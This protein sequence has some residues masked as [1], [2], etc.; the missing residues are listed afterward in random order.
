MSTSFGKDDGVTSRCCYAI[1]TIRYICLGFTDLPVFRQFKIRLMAPGDAGETTI[2]R[3]HGVKLEGH[4][5]QTI[6][7][8]AIVVPVVAL[9]AIGRTDEVS[10]PPGALTPAMQVHLVAGLGIRNEHVVVVQPIVHTE[11]RF[12]IGSDSGNIDE[13][14]KRATP[15][16][17]R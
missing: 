2:A 16:E 13:I 12:Q 10:W 3:G 4:S 6:I 14:Y 8:P 1:Y 5:D 11:E 15:V 9:S 17:Q 7:K